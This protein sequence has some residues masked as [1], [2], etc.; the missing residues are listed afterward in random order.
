MCAVLARHGYEPKTN[1]P[2]EIAL[3]DCPFHRLAEEQ[4]PLVCA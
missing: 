2:S 4:R 1:H 3:A